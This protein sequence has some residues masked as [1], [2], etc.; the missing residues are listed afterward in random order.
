MDTLPDSSKYFKG[1]HFDQEIIVLC[2]RWY[3]TYKLSYRDLGL[4]RSLF[5]F[6]TS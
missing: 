5:R 1:R 6:M 3:V 2:G 4:T